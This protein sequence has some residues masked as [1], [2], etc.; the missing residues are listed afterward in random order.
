MAFMSIV[1][2]FP[3]TE[4]TNAQNMNYT[5][6]VLGGVLILSLLWYY[7][8]VYGGVHW[9]AGPVPTVDGYV[10]RKWVEAAS[11]GVEGDVPVDVVKLEKDGSGIEIDSEVVFAR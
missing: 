8:P 6:V 1:F 9:F 3:T 5:V 4:Q 7:F 11:R 10:A 2:S